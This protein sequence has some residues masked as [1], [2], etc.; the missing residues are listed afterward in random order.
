[1]RRFYTE[2]RI[3][4]KA[5]KSASLFPRPRKVWSGKMG[6]EFGVFLQAA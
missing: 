1:M 5:W 6:K 2:F 3:F 4:E